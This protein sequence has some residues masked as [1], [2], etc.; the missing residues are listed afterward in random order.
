MSLNGGRTWS[1]QYNQPTA[2]LYQVYVDDQ[3][4]YR[5][6]GAQQDNTTVIVPS[7][8]LGTGMAE[9]WR[10]GPGC[11]TGPI[12]PDRINPDT[13]YGACKGQFGVMNLKVGQEKSYWTGAQSL[14]GNVG[15]D[16]IYRFQRTAPMEVSPHELHTVYYGSQYVHRTRDEG[17]TWDRI[18]PDLTAHDPRYQHV[19]SGEPITRDM[20]G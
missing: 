16:L 4:P 11:E 7:L 6:Y 14:Y 9:E 5:L 20:T 13:V 2:E 10:E 1:T 18:S 12:I 19:A 8:P 3:F 17:V 15:A